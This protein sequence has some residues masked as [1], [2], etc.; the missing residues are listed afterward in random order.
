MK[1]GLYI[2]L[3]IIINHRYMYIHIDTTWLP[4]TY[5]VSGILPCCAAVFLSST[6]NPI[7]A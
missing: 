6:Q 4:D 2:G 7:Y 5:N 3:F 1:R